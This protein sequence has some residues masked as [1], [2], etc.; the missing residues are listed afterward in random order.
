MPRTLWTSAEVAEYLNVPANTL[1]YWRN[2]AP[3]RGP[4]FVKLGP[5]AK[6]QVRYRPADVE[7]WL[8][9]NTVETAA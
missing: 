7:A 8:E 1:H 3:P 4:R 5:E 6:A 2:A 9:A